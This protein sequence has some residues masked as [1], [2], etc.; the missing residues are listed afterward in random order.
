MRLLHGLAKIHASFD[1]PNLVSRAGL[2]PV[3][4]LAQRAGLA[5]LAGEHVAIASRCGGNAHLKVPCL[6]AGMVAGA[7]S[8]DDM[9]LLRHGA[10]PA[11]FGGIRAPSTLGSF[12]RSFSWGNARQAEKVSRLLLAELARRTPLLPG[13]DVVAFVDID[14]MQ[15]RVYGR[16][17]QGAAFGHT[18]IQGKSLL[19]RGLNALT[20]TISTPLAAP[21]IAATR[22]RGGNAGSARG[23]ASFA[24]ESVSTARSTG[25]SGTLV[26]RA[27][28]AF[29]SAAFTA[30]VRRAGACFSVTVRMDPKVKAAI[31]AIPQTAW[32]AIRYP[33]AIWDDQLRA[34]V[35][36]AEVAETEYT[37]FTSK[38]G[39]PSPPG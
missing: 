25:C 38:K 7:D 3:M 34:W 2:V 39:R 35:S 9:D 28:A 16:K 12:L 19:V 11:L 20:A 32:T 10:M 13:K 23:A 26:V 22:L 17:K 21:V 31:A 18:K 24:A 29:Y 30:A 27:D 37:A 4:A 33:R 5:A 8:I 36:D 6:V 1:D 14:S 15:K